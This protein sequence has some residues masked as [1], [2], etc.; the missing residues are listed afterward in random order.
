MIGSR[1]ALKSGDFQDEGTPADPSTSSS[2][3]LVRTSG[4]PPTASRWTRW[5]SASPNSF[6]FATYGRKAPKISRTMFGGSGG[7]NPSRS[8]ANIAAAASFVCVTFQ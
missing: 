4:T 2:S 6:Q 3:S 8:H 1:V 7:R 5:T